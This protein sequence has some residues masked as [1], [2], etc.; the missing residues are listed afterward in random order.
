MLNNRINFNAVTNC[1][2]T[3]GKRGDCSHVIVSVSDKNHNSALGRAVLQAIQGCSK[4]VPDCRAVPQLIHIGEIYG[5][6]QK[7]IIQCGR[8]K[9]NCLTGKHTEA[10]PVILAPLY[11]LVHC[12]FRGIEP[13]FVAP[14][15]LNEHALRNVECK[16]DV[17]AF[18]IALRGR[19]G[20]LW[21]RQ[22]NEAKSERCGSER[23]WNPHRQSQMRRKVEIT[24]CQG[25]VQYLSRV[26]GTNRQKKQPYHYRHQ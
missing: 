6:M 20:R 16:H 21:S 14:H 8:A 15:I 7:I 12:F 9:R 4:A 1:D 17:D 18:G 5:R 25:E 11:E 23:E 26:L 3:G 2:I 24:V 22:R 10:D 13:V 19:G